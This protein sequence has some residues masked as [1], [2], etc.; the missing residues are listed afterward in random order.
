LANIYLYDSDSRHFI[1]LEEYIT[2][3][4]NEEFNICIPLYDFASQ[5]L[6]LNQVNK[7]SLIYEWEEVEGVLSLDEITFVEFP[8]DI[9]P[10]KLV[11]E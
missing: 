2:E 6:D 5:G 7:L 3:G 8:N 4:P 10:V 1:N 9:T 11:C